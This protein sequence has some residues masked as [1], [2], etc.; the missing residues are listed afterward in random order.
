MTAISDLALGSYEAAALMGV[1]FTRAAR[2]YQSGKIDGRECLP[3]QNAGSARTFLV[4]SA[5]SCNDDFLNYDR[6]QVGRPRA[7]V[8][9]RDE[10]LKRLAKTKPAIAYDDAIGIGDAAKLLK[11]HHTNVYKLIEAGK[12]IAR[13]PW[14]P[15]KGGARILIVSRSSCEANRR[16]VAALESVGKKRGRKRYA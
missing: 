5:R 4:Y 13:C 16:E 10:A 3:S 1:H 11:V 6:T 7:W 14:N 2:M 8:H 15:R 9:L 12:I